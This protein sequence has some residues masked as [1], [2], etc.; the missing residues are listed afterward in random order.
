MLGGHILG[1]RLKDQCLD[2]T[3]QEVVNHRLC[4]GLVNVVPA[5]FGTT[6]AVAGPCI[7]LHLSSRQRQQLLEHDLLT[8]G[9]DEA[10]VRQINRIDFAGR[11]GIE[12]HLDR[13]DKPL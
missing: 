1:N 4:I 10:R 13:A 5:M 8:H 9:V 2:I 6:G 11:I 3:H 12:Q 7:R